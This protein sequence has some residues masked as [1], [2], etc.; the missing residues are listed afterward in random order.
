MISTL[1]PEKFNFRNQL[2][3]NNLNPKNDQEKLNKT[4]INNEFLYD[5]YDIG[6][7]DLE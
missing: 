6:D 4:I 5:K 7:I 1:N 2:F 3:E